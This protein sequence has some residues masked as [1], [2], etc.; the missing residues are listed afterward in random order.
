MAEDRR[1][2]RRRFL[3]RGE[4]SRKVGL[5]SFPGSGNTWI[6]Y[7][8]EAATGIYTGSAYDDV[9]LQGG[10]FMGELV[11]P[12][13]FKVNVIKSHYMHINGVKFDA[14]INVYRDPYDAMLAEYNRRCKGHTG[15]IQMKKFRQ[16]EFERLIVKK[17][18]KWWAF[19]TKRTIKQDVPK[20]IFSYESL[21]Q[22][23]IKYAEKIARFVLGDSVNEM[24]LRKRLLCLKESFNGEFK[25]KKKSFDPYTQSMKEVMN[26]NIELFVNDLKNAGFT[27]IPDY[28][29]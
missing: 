15:T 14:I 13:S 19:L 20:L 5:I 3:R 9:D 1:C 7:L 22:S 21:L 8:I 6:R 17:W 4:L 11:S 10:G 12:K 24:E 27:D 29:R 16:T 28:R 26:K 25:R 18:I 2:G 23:P